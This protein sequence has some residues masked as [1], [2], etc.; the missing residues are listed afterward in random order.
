MANVDFNPKKFLSAI[1]Q[2]SQT[3]KNPTNQEEENKLV[4]KVYLSR[5]ENHGRYQIF[6]MPSTVTGMPFV[7]MQKTREIKIPRTL[8]KS[9]GTEVTYEY[10][11]KIL[12]HNAFNVVDNGREV[13]G[14]T[15]QESQLLTS[16]QM[17]FDR[18]YENMGGYEKERDKNLT[19]S[20]L[21]KK[22]YTI[23]FAKCLQK[24]GINN[25]RQAERMNFGALFI[26]AAKGFIE[27]VKD[28]I[29][30]ISIEENNE[31]WLGQIYNRDLT[32]RTGY[33]TFNISLPQN[34]VGYKLSVDHKFNSQQY[35]NEQILPEEAAL[36]TDPVEMF[37]GWQV[38]K[39]NHKN[40]NTRIMEE[41]LA[42]INS[43]LAK[44]P[45]RPNAYNSSKAQQPQTPASVDINAAY[46]S[47]ATN[48]ASPRVDPFTGGAAGADNNSW[49]NPGFAQNPWAT[50]GAGAPADATA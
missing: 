22:T 28:N 15:S 31:D 45:D 20:K 21:R 13:S 26:C 50:A 7:Q 5:P 36:M 10:W 40:F 29:Q 27:T 1:E 32:G 47:P 17:A 12:P 3:R 39:E 44:Y 46:G 49:N 30:E 6:P 34:I 14:L 16:V 23:F 18:L 11:V 38:D 48:T 43:E 9:D 35:A 24:W 41:T 33:M 42:Y 37:L 19:I 25:P 8:R 4:E 2:S